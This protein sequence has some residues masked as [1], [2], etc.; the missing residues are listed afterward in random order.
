M[1]RALVLSAVF[2]AGLSVAAGRVF[3]YPMPFAALSGTTAYTTVDLAGAVFGVR[4]LAA[5]IAWIQ[6]LQYY[7]TPEQPLIKNQEY[8]RSGAITKFLYGWQEVHDGQAGNDQEYDPQFGG[9][10]YPALLSYCYRI[11]ALD[12]FYTY[13]YLYGGGT[14]AWN[15][16]RP[17]EALELLRH[18]ITVMERYHHD[19]TRDVHQ[20]YWQLNLYVSAII[21]R[22][23]GD[24][25]AMVRLLETA[26]RQPQAPNMVKAIL[27]NIYQKQNNHPAAARLWLEIYDSK[28]PSYRATAEKKLAELQ[29][30]L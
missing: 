12:P 7:G 30:Y 27:A 13:A 8:R 17:D 22:T 25:A 23:S 15:L 20:P 5:D 28:D 2:L 21:Y 18:G 3:I 1:V 26:V 16:N 4:R 6:L 9:G 24:H 14:L 29:R 11:V 19:L 10:K